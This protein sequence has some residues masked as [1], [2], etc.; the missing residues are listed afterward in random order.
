MNCGLVGRIAEP[1]DLNDDSSSL[2][3]E[4]AGLDSPTIGSFVLLGLGECWGVTGVIGA[5]G[6]TGTIGVGG[7]EATAGGLGRSDGG[8]SVGPVFVR[9]G[10]S[11]GDGTAVD[12]EARVGPPK[13]P[14][15]GP[16]PPSWL[17]DGSGFGGDSLL[18][19]LGARGLTAAVAGIVGL[20]IDG[21]GGAIGG[22]GG[23]S[24][25]I[26]EDEGGGGVAIAG[27]LGLGASPAPT[28]LGSPVT[29]NTKSPIYTLSADFI[30]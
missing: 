16:T 1:G 12:L 17:D 9:F 8:D 27:G 7:L 4:G 30:T 11:D 29:I 26:I 14:L 3:A 15:F 18:S 19:G 13:I 22:E 6:A 20:P 10:G 25:F 21:G 24:G 23:C 2:F 5:T 28:L